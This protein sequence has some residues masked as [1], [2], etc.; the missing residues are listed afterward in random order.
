MWQKGHE[1]ASGGGLRGRRRDG[2]FRDNR[3]ISARCAGRLAEIT[4]PGAEV[5][6]HVSVADQG[7]LAQAF[8][9]IEAR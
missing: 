2:Q 8:V 5:F 3:C 9:V 7:P 1:S 6:I 4:S